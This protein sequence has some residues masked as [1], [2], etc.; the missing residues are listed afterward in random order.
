M[1][2]TL[3]CRQILESFEQDDEELIEYALKSV[4]AEPHD[5]VCGGEFG[6]PFSIGGYGVFADSQF[7]QQFE[8]LMSL[9]REHAVG[10]NFL[11]DGEWKVVD[12]GLTRI[13]HYGVGRFE[14]VVRGD[15]FAALALRKRAFLTAA[16]LLKHGVDPLLQNEDGE[17][18]FDVTKIMYG[19]MAAELRALDE[20]REQMSVR[21]VPPSEIIKNETREKLLKLHYQNMIPLLELH[22]EKMEDRL[23]HIETVKMEK[24]RRDLKRLEIPNEMHWEIG[25]L[26]RISKHIEETKPLIDYIV[27]KIMTIDKYSAEGG[28][29]SLAHLL[30]EQRR[31]L[32][33]ITEELGINKKD[34]KA[35]SDEKK[36]GQEEA[37]E[38]DD[39]D[40][41]SLAASEDSKH[42]QKVRLVMGLVEEESLDGSRQNSKKDKSKKPKGPKVTGILEQTELSTTYYI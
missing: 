3:W 20:F 39:K 15:T 8:L 7:N 27:E 26:S 9:E 22:K 4:I 18:F 29:K 34:N 32:K 42:Q 40:Q 19:K 17:D 5:R 16:F 1:H 2:R 38:E 31:A 33:N 23:R 12:D 37:K 11:S 30:D 21:L 41:H 36:D 6:S 28:E 10:V 24:R 25:N 14:N 35:G 13:S